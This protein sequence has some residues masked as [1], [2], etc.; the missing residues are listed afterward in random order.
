MMWEPARLTH[1][2]AKVRL[3]GE[4]PINFGFN[5]ELS[6]M[7]LRMSLRHAALSHMCSPAVGQRIRNE[8]D[9]QVQTLWGK[10]VGHAAHK[11]Y[12]DLL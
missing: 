3:I 4:L 9:Q 7:S 1:H 10:G 11:S 2:S 6:F 12:G 5:T 8:V